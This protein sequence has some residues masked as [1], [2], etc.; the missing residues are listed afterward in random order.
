[1]EKF[2]REQM[3]ERLA[4]DIPP[5]SYVNLGIGIPVLVAN[6]LNPEDEVLLHSENG[7]LGM[8]P[9]PP[10][11]EEDFELINAGKQP[12]TLLTGGSFFHHVDSFAIMR[13][14]H[15]D[16]CIMGGMQVAANGD[17]ANWS[18]GRPGEPPAVGGAM[19]LAVGAKKVYILMEHNSKDGSPKILEKCTLPVTGLGVVSRIYTDIA[20][21]E[22]TPEGV[23]VI[24]KLVD[25]SDEDLQARTGAKL[26]F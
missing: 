26:I 18:L 8:G 22:I 4:K 25:I 5:G 13:G 19:D 1:M 21:L 6:Y 15:L 9:T 14:G 24:E 7:I 17:L 20:V 2:T 11:G 23:K 12:V 3:A 16:L 10:E